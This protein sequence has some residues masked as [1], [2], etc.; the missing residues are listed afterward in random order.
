MNGPIIYGEIART[1]VR[2]DS[3]ELSARLGGYCTACHG[4]ADPYISQIMDVISV[5]YSVRVCEVK[6][7]SDDATEICGVRFVS[8]A[9]ARALSGATRAYVLA[10]TLG[11]EVDRYLRRQEISSPSAHYIADAV[12]SAIA[13]AAC[14]AAQRGLPDEC[15]G[16]P[17]FSVGY[18]DLPLFYQR[19]V[20]KLL[21]GERIG[22]SL[23][24]SY[25]MMPTKSI[26]AIIGIK[27][28]EKANT[29]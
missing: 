9:L 14:D 21:C 6:R 20:L 16:A 10:V 27:N 24:D 19:D 29:T 23:T 13:E 11:S 12:A 1:D 15:K 26:T 7:I 2:I 22:I 3:R 28:E 25:L 17:R 18:A 4:I 8:S 5:K